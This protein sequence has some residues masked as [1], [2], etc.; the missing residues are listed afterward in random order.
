MTQDEY[1]NRFSKVQKVETIC[2]SED[3]SDDKVNLMLQNG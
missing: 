1:L 2:I 3:Y